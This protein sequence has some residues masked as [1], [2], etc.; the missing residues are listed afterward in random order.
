MK[1]AIT[2][3]H[4]GMTIT[5]EL[6]T[7][8]GVVTSHAV[9]VTDDV[10]RCEDE[11]VKG[12]AP[13]GNKNAA[14]KH[15]ATGDF[16]HDVRTSIG[17][18]GNLKD[19]IGREI[20]TGKA[21]KT[22]KRESDNASAEYH[23]SPGSD[24][25]PLKEKINQEIES[26]T[27]YSSAKREADKAGREHYD[28]LKSAVDLHGEKFHNERM[29]RL[30]SSDSAKAADEAREDSTTIHAVWTDAAREASAEARRTHNTKQMTKH[31]EKR[32]NSTRKD[33]VKLATSKG[34]QEAHAHEHYNAF[35]R[36]PA[37]S[38][39]EVFDD[40]VKSA[41]ASTADAIHARAGYQVKGSEADAPWKQGEETKFVFMPAGVHTITAGF[42]KGSINLTVKVDKASATAAQ[43]SLES[44]RA[45]RPKQK[46]YGCVEHR[47]QEASVI[48]HCFESDEQGNVLLACE[49]TALGEQNVNGKIHW[50][51]SPSFTTDAEYDKCKCGDCGLDASRGNQGAKVCACAK[52][53]LY[54]PR[55]VRGS[56]AA[57]AKVTGVDFV[58]GTLTNRPA[59]H[60]MPP[61]KASEAVQAAGNSEGARKGW[62]ER[63][64]GFTAQAHA[65]AIGDIYDVVNRGARPS[66]ASRHA[67]A[68]SAIADKSGTKA[69]HKAAH[70]AHDKAAQLHQEF[71][72]G[73]KSEEHYDKSEQHKKA[74]DSAKASDQASAAATI[75]ATGNSEGA[76][77]GW[78]HRAGHLFAEVGW[79]GK[80]SIR[81]A[82][83]LA[84]KKSESSGKKSDH[85][86]AASL[87]EEAAADTRRGNE[88]PS[89]KETH[90]KYHEEMARYH[91]KESGTAKASDVST[92]LA[93]HRPPV[94][95]A[96]AVLRRLREP[97]KAGAPFGNRNAAG[98]R[99][100]VTVPADE[101]KRIGAM[102]DEASKGAGD[103]ASHKRAMQLHGEAAAWHGQ[104]DTASTEVKRH[105]DKAQE[106]KAAIE[107]ITGKPYKSFLDQFRN[108]ASETG[109]AS[110]ILARVSQQAARLK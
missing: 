77:K 56:A 95:G 46:P 19:K 106:H 81:S 8:T 38:R 71:G 88:P 2:F 12:G 10:V 27:A 13:V 89:S 31:L 18:L 97:V 86:L 74:A 48:A 41:E 16:D 11:S 107:K 51:W 100:Q 30:A 44:L 68:A 64:K 9:A 98:N 58:L 54:F 23:A 5:G 17:F 40:D 32:W 92:I 55:G 34:V 28:H 37:G 96:A 80:K 83:I 72:S 21:H 102:A 6:D 90:R 61:V 73:E 7:E 93:A 63:H 62:E 20:E 53:A 103:E 75:Q 50:S 35:N 105:K 99:G 42:R 29:K 91:S 82:A 108:K 78:E 14:G 24:I 94:T 52:P 39:E 36:L 65:D 57:P 4:N 47:E 22:A 3:V 43:A 59:F 84:S 104:A 69:D 87:H 33:F 26:R 110:T 101:A 60:E 109:S 25:G 79:S 66:E 67:H 49:P 1:Q 76:R 45:S 85:A 15:L 70:E